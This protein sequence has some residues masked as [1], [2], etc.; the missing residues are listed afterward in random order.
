MGIVLVRIDDRLIH[1][2]VVVGWARS[3][4][5]DRIVV[6]NDRIRNEKLQRT[7]MEVSAMDGMEIVV[8]GIDEVASMMMDRI[9]NDGKTILLLES[10]KD[11]LRLVEKGVRFKEI[12]VGCMGGGE[13]KRKIL[14]Y[15]FVDEEDERIFT[16]LHRLGISIEARALPNDQKIDLMRLIKVNGS[17]WA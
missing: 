9:F 11:A 4:M 2:Q 17:S 5:V 10:P 13:G 16:E 12:N 14:P 8:R 6:A 1:G 7:L 3:L 15:I